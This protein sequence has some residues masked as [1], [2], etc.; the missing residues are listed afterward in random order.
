MID[1]KINM[2][3]NPE[4]VIHLATQVFN[5]EI[6][7]INRVLHNLNHDFTKAVEAILNCSGKVIVTGM[8]KSGHISG[9]IAATLA[10][11]GTPA[12]FVHPAEALHGDLGMISSGDIVIAIS[13][14]GESDELISILPAVKRKNTPIIAITGN[15]ES[16]LAK[17]SDYVLSIKIDKEACPLNLA[18]T[19][20]TT[21][22]LV[23]GDAL[24]VCLLEMR[25]F[26]KEDFALFHPGGSIGR[27]LLTTVDD[28]M[29]TK[30]RLPVVT[31]DTTL[32]DVVIEISKKGLGFA[33]VIDPQN[34]LVGVITDGDLRR[35]LNHDIN[36][37]TVFAKDIMTKSPRVLKSGSLAIDATMLM[38][39]YK[40]TGFLV[41]DNNNCLIGAFNLHDLIKA[42]LI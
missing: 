7:G 22:S 4:K 34:K 37:V 17:F 26:K 21:V 8:G 24:A 13:Y 5:D 40:I 36:V 10:S 32:K 41:I 2:E 14:S 18:P 20:S 38:Q 33:G 3:L 11:T 23:L 15:I 28:L 16:T 42:K 29:Y 30:E 1:K 27:R 9:K 31:L 12:F 25:G 35:I 39:E 6:E 19:T